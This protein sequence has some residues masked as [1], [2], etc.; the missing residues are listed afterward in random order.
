MNESFSP[1]AQHE[2]I[3]NWQL[4]GI[5]DNNDVQENMN[6]DLPVLTVNV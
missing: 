2:R 1:N 4:I 3:T 6:H 5:Q